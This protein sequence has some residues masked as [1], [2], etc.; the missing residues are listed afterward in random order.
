MTTP[1]KPG[2]R[3]SVRVDQELS[4]DLA[5]IMRTCPTL[6]DAVR[7]AVSIVAD[8]YRNAWAMGV[9]PDGVQPRIVGH[10]VMPYEGSPT[11]SDRAQPASSSTPRPRPTAGPTPPN[12][13]R[14]TR[15]TPR[16]TP[17]RRGP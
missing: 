1:P 3:P 17:V 6:A 2:D 16:P 14:P 9:V 4:D 12:E 7:H 8:A 11:P 5:V 10:D 13:P 15:H